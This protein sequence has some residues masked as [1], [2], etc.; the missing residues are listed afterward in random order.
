MQDQNAMLI[1]NVIFDNVIT[2][3]WTSTTYLSLGMYACEW[4]EKENYLC[5]CASVRF[6]VFGCILELTSA[7]DDEITKCDQRVG[8]A[9][10]HINLQIKSNPNTKAITLLQWNSKAKQ[11]FS[12]ICECSDFSNT[13]AMV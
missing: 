10:S 9:I 13:L 2:L 6:P 7:N 5:F 8:S 11:Q 12:N 4:T 3:W 1:D